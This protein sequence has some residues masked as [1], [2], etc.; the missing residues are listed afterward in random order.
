M[1]KLLIDRTWLVQFYRFVV[2]ISREAASSSDFLP[3]IFADYAD[4]NPRYSLTQ[5]KLTYRYSLALTANRQ[6][7]LPKFNIVCRD[8][9]TLIRYSVAYSTTVMRMIR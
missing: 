6:A 3:G 7:I 8:R 5:F 9:L 1:K 4:A 2:W